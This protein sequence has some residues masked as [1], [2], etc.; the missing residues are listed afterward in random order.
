MDRVT[1]PSTKAST[2]DDTR[3]VAA[4]LRTPISMHIQHLAVSRV[5]VKVRSGLSA[6][7]QFVAVHPHPGFSDS[8][9][10]AHDST[11]GRV[12]EFSN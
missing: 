10:T 7:Q 8:H 11:K 2:G 4:R 9:A 5:M 12:H 6:Q 3:F 1:K